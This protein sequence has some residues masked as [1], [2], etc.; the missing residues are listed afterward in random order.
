MAGQYFFDFFR[1][2]LLRVYLY[3]TDANFVALN[4]F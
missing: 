1:L 3:N 4:I 2:I